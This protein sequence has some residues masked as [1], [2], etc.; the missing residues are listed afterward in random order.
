[1][2]TDIHTHGRPCIGTREGREVTDSGRTAILSVEPSEFDAGKRGLYSVGFHPWNLG[3]SGPSE[4]EWK[5]F[6]TLARRKDVV[7]IGECGLDLLKGPVLAVQMN[8]FRRQAETA[9]RL[10]KPVII[11]C[12]KG[13]E[14][15]IGLK[16]IINPKV[17]WIIHGFRG[18]PGVARMLI[19]S[20]FYLS[21]GDK[22]N[23]ASLSEIPLSRLFV[24]TDESELTIEE[25]TDAIA[26][27]RGIEK[28]TLGQVTERNVREVFGDLD[29]I[30]TT[31]QD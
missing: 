12:V 9:E 4:A 18:K 15:L 29:E 25:I 11:H 14:Q 5:L 27:A 24:E 2:I 26:M 17:A 16:K 23:P 7:A 28:D 19:S 20:G 3:T 6:D 30:L 8:V 13:Y 21:L 22:F 10:N 1:M 31:K